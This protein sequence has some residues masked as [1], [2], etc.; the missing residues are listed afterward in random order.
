MLA[1]R[2]LIAFIRTSLS[3]FQEGFPLC[4]FLNYVLCVYLIFSSL[5]FHIVVFLFGFAFGFLGML[6]LSELGGGHCLY[7]DLFHMILF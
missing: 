4:F 7:L 6:G 1:Q 2:S 5:F 3:L